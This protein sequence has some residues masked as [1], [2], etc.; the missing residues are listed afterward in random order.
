MAMA[1]FFDRLRGKSRGIT[2]WCRFPLRL[3]SLQQ[4]ERQLAFVAAAEQV[5][6]RNAELIAASGGTA[7]DP[8]AVGFYVG[9]GNTPNTLSRDENMLKSYISD[10]RKRMAH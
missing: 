2:A 7:G 3:L 5:R 10:P 8:F 9:E 1:L 6:L 4:T